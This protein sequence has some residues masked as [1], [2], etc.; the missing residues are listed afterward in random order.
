MD[1]ATFAVT[2]IGSFRAD[3]ARPFY[4]KLGYWASGEEYLDEYCPHI[5]MEKEL[6]ESRR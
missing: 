3:P 6:P 5:H 1:Q 2:V 4:E